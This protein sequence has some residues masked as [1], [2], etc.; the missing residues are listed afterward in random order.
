VQ[1]VLINQ[2][3]RLLIAAVLTTAVACSQPAS[4]KPPDGRES[5]PFLSGE[6]IDL[7][8][9]YDAKTIY[10][11]TADPF[12]LD[13]VADG[14]TPGGYYYAANNFFTSE[15]GGT[16]L[17]AP[18]HFAQNHWS[19]D[20]VP[21]DRLIGSAVVVDVV[22]SA[23]Q[24]A[25]YQVSVDDLLKWE[26]AHGAIPANAILLLRTGFSTRWPDAVRY[27]GTAER[28]QDAVAKLHFPGLQPDAAR[29]LVANR[30]IKALGID[31][32]SID[33]G[34][35]TLYESHQVLYARDIPAFENLTNLGR[36]P[37][38]GATI[39]ALPMKIGG[40]SGAPLRAIAVLPSR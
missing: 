33:F 14:V 16:H 18:V 1:N 29:W 11:P 30:S 32:A 2:F 31:T 39:I 24:Q 27:L 28:G 21:L 36:L 15:H 22:A 19:V 35:S 7:S 8:H 37:V 38:T 26:K 17:D 13:K 5:G 3:A 34:Q 25:D 9:T 6:L 12:R 23:E 20:Q 4:P 10:W 40:G